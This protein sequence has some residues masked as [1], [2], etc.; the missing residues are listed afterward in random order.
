MCIGQQ[1]ILWF[2]DVI[3]VDALAQAYGFKSGSV[4]TE[5]SSTLEIQ[6]PPPELKNIGQ[7]SVS[8]R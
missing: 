1:A 4:A 6:A 3:S 7:A 2:I 8:C 5:E